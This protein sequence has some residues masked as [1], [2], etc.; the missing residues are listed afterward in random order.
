M[1]LL[2]PFKKLEEKVNNTPQ[3]NIK[4]CSSE[5]CILIVPL[6]ESVRAYY[7]ISKIKE[8]MRNELYPCLEL[9]YNYCSHDNLYIIKICLK[10]GYKELFDTYEEMASSYQP[11][12]D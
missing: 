6:G 10:E 8:D 7:H 2:N 5:D 4:H 3:L 11:K 12:E 9:D 1:I